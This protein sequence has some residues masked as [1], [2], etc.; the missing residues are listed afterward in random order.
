MTN[1]TTSRPRWRNWGGNHA[2]T[3]VRLVHCRDVDEVQAAVAWAV[4]DGLTVRPIGLGHSSSPAA[5][6]TGVIVRIDRMNALRSVDTR[7]CIVEVAAGAQIHWLNRELDEYGLALPNLGDIDHQTLAGAIST[8]SHGTGAT[9]Q[10]LASD[11]VGLQ[12]V[13]ADGSV[14]DCSETVRPDLFS[15]ARTS[16]GVLGIITSISLRTVPAFLL[17]VVQDKQGFAPIIERLDDSFDAHEGFE[18]DWYPHTDR[19]RTTSRDRTAAADLARRW[20]TAADELASGTIGASAL[21][22]AARAPRVTRTINERLARMPVLPPHADASYR[23]L[24]GRRYV[25]SIESEYAVERR[26]LGEVLSLVKSWVDGQ[27]EQ[28]ALPVQV[29]AAAADDVWLSPAYQRDTGYVAVRGFNRPATARYFQAFEAIAREYAGRPHLGTVHGLCAEGMR[30]A[31]PRFDDLVR[32][33]DE[34]DPGRVFA[35][36]YASRLFGR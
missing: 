35:N 31:Y 24:T 7:T 34:V 25:R 30:A 4:A 22:L 14:V 28:V 5:V 29:R 1:T 20:R 26:H 33:R 10:G 23:S 18:F 36:D 11:V 16:L 17:R 2:T 13:L 9:L 6:G 12:I 21:R 8:G 15:A 3:Y 32:V 27:D 19:V